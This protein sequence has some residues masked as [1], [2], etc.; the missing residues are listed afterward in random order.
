MSARTSAYLL[1][2]NKTV[3][4]LL[5]ADLLQR[6]DPA[7]GISKRFSYVGM[8][9]TYMEDFKLLHERFPKMRMTCLEEI[10]QVSKRQ[11]YNRPHSAIRFLPVTTSRWLEDEIQTDRQLVVWFDFQG[12]GRQHQISQFQTLIQKVAKPSI[13]RITLDVTPET[14]GGKALP[15]ERLNNL[16]SQLSPFLPH[17]LD[18]EKFSATPL[19]DLVRDAAIRAGQLA[20]KG[21]KTARFHPLLVSSYRDTSRMLTVTG[22][23]AEREDVD[24]VIQQSR[25]DNWDFGWAKAPET[26]RIELPEMSAKERLDLNQMLPSRAKNLDHIHRQ[27]GFWF[28]SEEEQSKQM[29]RSYIRFARHYPQFARVTV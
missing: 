24:R 17:D 2:P 19:D 29:M 8:G 6:I 3:D 22:I 7:L 4:R 13:V 16:K 5:F 26:L 1:R 28:S 21:Q 18:V 14:L 9:G 20:L 10:P 25:L 27:F 15:T 12:T 11:H 23:V